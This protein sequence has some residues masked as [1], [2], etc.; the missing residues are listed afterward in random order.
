MAKYKKKRHKKKDK[1]ASHTCRLCNEKTKLHKCKYCKEYF[2]KE[3]LKAKPPG[4]PRFRGTSHE[5][6]LFME[7]WH[8]PGGHPCVSY[9]EYWKAKN[10]REKQ[11]YGLALDRLLKSKPHQ[12]KKEEK[13]QEPIFNVPI[14]KEKQNFKSKSIQSKKKRKRYEHTY[15]GPPVKKKQKNY[16]KYI[17]FG[18]IL[19]AVFLFINFSNKDCSD[20]THSQ[21]CS[22]NKPFFCQRFGSLVEN[23]SVCGCPENE[24]EYQNSCIQIIECEDG[25]LHPECSE[26]KP[27]QCVNGSLAKRASICGCPDEY[28]QKGKSNSCEPIQRCSDGTIYNQCSDDKPYLCVNGSLA[29]RATVCGCPEGS[30]QRGPNSNSCE[31]GSKD[32]DY[33]SNF[34]CSFIQ[35]EYNYESDETASGEALD[36]INEY[37][38][39]N[40]VST[41]SF[42]SRVFNLAVA[43]AKDMR[44]NSYLDHTNP[45]TG[46]CPDNMKSEYGLSSGEYVAENAFGN[47]IYFEGECTEIQIRPLTEPVDSWM[48]STGHRFNLLYSGHTA[49]AVG[50]Y[51]NMCVFLGLNYDRFG[52]G[53]YTAAEGEAFWDSMPE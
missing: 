3:H 9:L 21:N 33:S 46:S 18:L 39:A 14:T 44:E 8:K 11:E 23:P 4:M 36:Y 6:H 22:I 15:K 1:V 48:T 27:Y 29:I 50:C 34:G 28:M 16:I 53:C 52:E 2:C 20:G 40:G 25:T 12:F 41:I 43:R 49:G 7:E 51:K 24:R 42:D 13:W 10:E 31:V 47:P 19:F 38:Q 35:I 26:N 45:Y 32:S 37:R 17:I 30:V 5:D